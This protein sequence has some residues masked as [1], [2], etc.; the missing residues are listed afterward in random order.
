MDVD[1]AG[2]SRDGLG[3]F[4]HADSNPVQARSLRPRRP[5]AT[6]E[7]GQ[8]SPRLYSQDD[9]S[10]TDCPLNRR[11]SRLQPRKTVA[12]IEIRKPRGRL[13][14]GVARAGGANGKNS[15]NS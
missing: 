3:P 15:A 4:R 8:R 7:N 9:V 14:I 12:S 6:V 13:T 11:A 1:T 5:Y 10:A 2:G